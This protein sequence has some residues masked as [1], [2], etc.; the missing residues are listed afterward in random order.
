[1]PWNPHFSSKHTNA[2]LKHKPNIHLVCVWIAFLAVQRLH[3]PF[4]FFFYFFE[5]RI[6]HGNMSVSESRALCMGPTTSLNVQIFHWNVTVQWV[7]C[8]VHET[9]KPLL[10]TKLLLKMGPMV[11]FTHLKIILLQ[12]FQFSIFCKISGIQTNP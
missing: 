9:H 2:D 11:L 6:S 4:F 5:K 7:P 12:C 8:T 3:F 10:S 1:M